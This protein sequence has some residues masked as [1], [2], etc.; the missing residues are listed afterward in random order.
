MPEPAE[1]PFARFFAIALVLCVGGI[2]AHSAMLREARPQL[3]SWTQTTAV[4]DTRLYPVADAPPLT[5][6]GKPLTPLHPLPQEVRESRVVFVGEDDSKRFRVY[7]PREDA[8]ETGDAE[9]VYLV[10]T[11]ESRFLKLQIGGK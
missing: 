3:E 6:Q 9:N 7:Q 11:G 8:R 10:K 1:R 5:L 4:G 2:V